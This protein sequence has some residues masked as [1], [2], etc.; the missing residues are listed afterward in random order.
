M[1]GL[2]KGV[3]SEEPVFE[4]VLNW[5]K[6]DLEK[7]TEDLPKLL[8][9]VR[10]PL[11]SVRYITDVVD[12]QSLIKASHACRDLVDEAKTFHLRPDLRSQLHG[13][14]T[15]PRTG[16]VEVLVVVGG[17]GAMQNPVDS[18][19]M[20]DPKSNEWESLPCL[21]KRRRYVTAA[22]VGPRLYVIGGYDGQ[23]RLSLVECLDISQ[24]KPAWH[25]VA[26]MHHRRGL[27]GGCVYQ[28]MIFVCGGFDGTNR[29][30]S[31]ERYDPRI[32]QWTLLGSMLLGREGAGLVV[33]SDHI[34]C[35]GGYDG[36]NLL[37]SVEKYDPRTNQWAS[38][39]PLATS[40]S[41]AGVAVLNDTIFV[42]G[43]YDGNTHLSSVET[44]NV[45]T[46]Q[47]SSISSMTSPRCYV[48]ACVLRG[49]LYVVAGYDG[50]TLLKNME[51]YDPIADQWIVTESTM[52]VKRCDSGVAVV[53]GI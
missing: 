34:Y 36:V 26:P 53:K 43:G 25:A 23:S 45:R 8:Q 29:H 37:N 13:S 39:A 28:D 15:K 31:L 16:S 10:L 42:C 18:A 9:L 22:A 51:Y 50:H 46:C 47:W 30:T 4:A 7:R 14:R 6:L 19:E 1:V 44:Y 33:A 52:E 12:N 32:D 24:D 35:L 27:A 17:F 41:G 5:V 38:V 3:S 49:K 21:T 11:L 2:Q 20:F 40:R 48:G